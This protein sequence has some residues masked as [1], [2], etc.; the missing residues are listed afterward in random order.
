[1]FNEIRSNTRDSNFNNKQ[2]LNQMKVPVLG[3]IVRDATNM[4]TNTERNSAQKRFYN[5]SSFFKSLTPKLLIIIFPSFSPIWLLQLTNLYT[6]QRENL[7]A[8]FMLIILFFFPFQFI[9][10]KNTLS[11]LL[12][13][14]LLI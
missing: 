8:S 10:N 9:K 14:S 13:M 3:N 1:M 7:I 2:F 6:N 4:K 5:I 11:I 12:L